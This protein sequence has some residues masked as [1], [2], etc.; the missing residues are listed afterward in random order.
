MTYQAASAAWYDA[1]VDAATGAVLRRANMV[2]SPSTANVFENYP[3][4]PRR[5]RPG[6]RVA[7]PVPHRR[8]RGDD[9][10]GPNAHAWSD[11]DDDDVATAGEEVDP[12]GG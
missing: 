9:A 3:G 2:D 6:A 8:R 4:A 10:D 1:V 7:R 5:R 11:I 12:S